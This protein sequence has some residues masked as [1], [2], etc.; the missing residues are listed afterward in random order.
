MC[1]RDRAGKVIAGNE[2]M[3]LRDQLLGRLLGW[4]PDGLGA[5]L[6]GGMSMLALQPR[7]VWFQL[8]FLRRI[9][10]RSELP[11]VDAADLDAF[12]QVV[13]QIHDN[14]DELVDG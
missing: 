8:N 1:I 4:S 9:G 13:Q 6:Y 5:L 11:I 2:V 14:V 12:Y 10:V 3:T 7:T